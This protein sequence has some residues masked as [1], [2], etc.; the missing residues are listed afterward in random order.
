M[1]GCTV[2]DLVNKDD[3]DVHDKHKQIFSLLPQPFLYSAALCKKSIYLQ[4]VML[5]LTSVSL[6]LSVCLSVWVRVCLRDCLESYK[7]I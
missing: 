6:L 7:L 1:S 3:D 2:F 5:S 4:Q